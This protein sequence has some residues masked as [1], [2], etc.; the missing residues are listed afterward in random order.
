MSSTIKVG[1][2][3]VWLVLLA[4]CLT[5]QACAAPDDAPTK[6]KQLPYIPNP[7]DRWPQLPPI[8]DYVK[9]W[10]KQVAVEK[11]DPVLGDKPY[12]EFWVYSEA[13]AKRFK[14]FPPEGADPELKGGVHAMVARIL[15][16]NLWSGVNPNYPEQYTCHL[17]VYFDSSIKLPLSERPWSRSP[18][19]YPQGVSPSYR[20]LVP[21]DAQ[22]EQA[23]RTSERA[24]MYPKYLPMIFV[25]KPLDGRFSS[26]G[27][28][29]YHPNLVP[30]LAN[31]SLSA[32]SVN[33]AC[34]ITAPK[35]E[36][37]VFWLSLFGDN[38]YGIISRYSHQNEIYT[39]NIK[40][41]FDPGPNPERAGY[42]RMPEALNRAMLPKEALIKMLNWCINQE[43]A[44]STRSGKGISKEAWDDIS[45]RC[46]DAEE[47]GKIDP[48]YPGRAGLQGAGF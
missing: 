30:G 7:M 41:T 23:I 8:P 45:R 26:L 9:A 10:P 38:P 18:P 22:D 12:W 25:D 31:L 19:V 24:P 2:L 37:G 36:K 40:L 28:W 17:D 3:H 46:R 29:E 33:G 6:P 14:G 48:G 27:M 39:R 15:K 5:A 21:F 16:L 47:R 43:F 42:V 11:P 34:S 1:L 4:F 20:R 44:H 35:A 32:H 13:F